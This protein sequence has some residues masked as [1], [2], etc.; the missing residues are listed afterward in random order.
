[1]RVNLWPLAGVAMALS[2]AAL[3][4]DAAFIVQGSGFWLDAPSTPYSQS[5]ESYD[6]S[7]DLARDFTP[8]WYSSPD[9]AANTEFSNFQYYLNGAPVAGIPQDIAFFD[10][11]MYGGLQL[12]FSSSYSVEFIGD[13]MATNFGQ[14]R[15][16]LMLGSYVEYPN[17]NFEVDANGVPLD[18]GTSI[19][20]SIVPEPAAWAMAL[21]GMFGVGAVARARRHRLIAA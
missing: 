16:T 7:F 3:P 4:A 9:I 11:G 19:R 12:A 17:M 21:L 14:P 15:V 20:M 18:Q 1:M 2:L 6:F 10:A 5:G 8:D 13:Q